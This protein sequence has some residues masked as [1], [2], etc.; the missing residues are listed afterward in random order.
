VGMLK[1]LR[2]S[3]Q[4]RDEDHARV[5]EFY[6]QHGISAEVKPF[7]EDVPRRMSETQLVITRA[8]ASTIADLSVIGRPSILVPLAAAIRDEQTANAR[9]LVEAGAAIMI[10]ESQLTPES[11][12]TQIA[13]VL[14]QPDAALQ[15]AQAALA[16]GKPEAADALAQIVETLA[17][18]GQSA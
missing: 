17:Y 14:D 11:L 16:Q 13:T 12:A 15:M 7:F 5:T 6:T 9:G 18:E 8:G 1:N 4:A 10:P 3:H 2:I